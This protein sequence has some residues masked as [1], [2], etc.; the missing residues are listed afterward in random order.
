MTYSFSILGR[1]VAFSSNDIRT[2]AA[3]TKLGAMVLA[4][5]FMGVGDVMAEDFDTD[6]GGGD[7]QIFDVTCGFLQTIQ[8]NLFTIIYVLGA[9]GLVIIAATAFMGNFRWQNLIALGGGL[10]VV[11]IADLIVEFFTGGLG[12]TECTF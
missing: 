1:R 8:S 5:L 4:L 2:L 11:A 3:A 7:G 6:I 12:D 9:I 10:F